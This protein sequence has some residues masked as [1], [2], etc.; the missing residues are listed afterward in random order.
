MATVVSATLL[1]Y[2]VIATFP[3]CLPLFLINKPIYIN[4]GYPYK[5]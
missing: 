1:F 2:G 4:M 5:R 3:K